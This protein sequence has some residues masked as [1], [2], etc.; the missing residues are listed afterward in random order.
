MNFALQIWSQGMNEDDVCPSIT[1]DRLAYPVGGTTPIVGR[2]FYEH[3]LE[4]TNAFQV[5]LSG[6]S[7][8]LFQG[9]TNGTFKLVSVSSIKAKTYSPSLC[10]AVRCILMKRCASLSLALHLSTYVRSPSLVPSECRRY[11]LYCL[12]RKRRKCPGDIV[13]VHLGFT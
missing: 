12:N 9:L 8:F 6:S 1:S 5:Y 10:L 13:S 2:L 11:N 4:N 3:P 7:T